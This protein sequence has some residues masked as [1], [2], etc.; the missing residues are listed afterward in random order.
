ME[1]F[2]KTA[3]MLM[4]YTVRHPYLLASLYVLAFLVAA[5]LVDRICSRVLVRYLTRTDSETG[6]RI[7]A[8]F[9][10]PVFITVILA[11]GLFAI[12]SLRIDDSTRIWMTSIF[13]T[14]LILVWTVLT[15]RLFRISFRAMVGS[16]RR[17]GF[18]NASTA[19]VF[20][21][22]VAVLLLLV[23]SY[24][25]LSIWDIDVTGLV[26]SAGILGLALSLAAQ[27]TLS[28]LFSG[29]SILADRP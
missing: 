4:E 27:E 22:G 11:G 28:N 8:L 13:G 5:V 3:A 21:N 25:I 1:P 19:P 9:H 6:N 20:G 29:I 7:V 24:G 15:Y 23:G 12:N 18:A 17:F 26:A 16:E 10:R 2:Q 14:I